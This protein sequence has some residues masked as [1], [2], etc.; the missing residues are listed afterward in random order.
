MSAYTV[1]QN[2]L[3]SLNSQPILELCQ[4]TGHQVSV[5][6]RQD[7]RIKF[8]IVGRGYASPA[9]GTTREL[10]QFADGLLSGFL[11]RSL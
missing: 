4:R 5:L 7:G 2:I 11:E 10:S 3:G 8:L 9:F 1:L 6:H